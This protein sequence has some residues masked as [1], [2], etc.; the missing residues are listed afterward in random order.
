MV[1]SEKSL[2]EEIEQLVRE[3]KAF[4]AEGSE[5]LNQSD[6]KSNFKALE[7]G[8]I[9]FLGEK[10]PLREKQRSIGKVATAE[11]R[12]ALGKLVNFA[13]QEI[14]QFYLKSK[15]RLENK[16]IEEDLKK[17]RIDPT[18]PGILN[19]PRGSLHPIGIVAEEIKQIFEELGFIS[20]E[21]PEIETEYYN[22]TALNTPEGHPARD[23][24]D[25]FYTNAGKDILLRSQTSPV[26]IRA[27]EKYGS[28]LRAISFGKVYRNEETNARKLP[29]FHQLEILCLDEKITLQNLKWVID[30][31]FQK[32][33]RKNIKFR[34][35]PDFFPFTEP[36][37]EVDA[38]C[39]FCSGAG[40]ATCG[41]KG[42]LELMG[43]G[44]IDPFVLENSKI[45]SRKNSGFA[46]G[47]G[48]ERFAM[49]KFGISDIRDFYRGDLR[50]LRQ[51]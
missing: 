16:K 17:E 10:S 26:Q 41:Y 47:I 48:I 24:Q 51:F 9:I 49:L 36:S 11:E 22:F 39:S 7:Q 13:R 45:D 18:L 12:R 6:L 5:K 3:A 27:L 37:F 31:F 19:S 28:P 20:L 1:S 14:S 33:F 40:C 21:G 23:E 2:Q 50:F 4:F 44:M 15:T 8:R 42:W 46:A 25:T 29:F 43:A 32:F 35:R 38:Q 30:H 34:L